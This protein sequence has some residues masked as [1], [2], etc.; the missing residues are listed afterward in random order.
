MSLSIYQLKPK[1]QQLLQPLL[2][3]LARWK[4][5]PNQVTILAVLLSLAYGTSLACFPRDYRLWA[6][7][8]LFMFLRMALNAIDGMLANFTGQKTALGAMLNEICD[9]ISDAALVLPFALVNGV[10]PPLLIIVALLA[11]LVEFAGVAALLA[12]SARRFDGPMGKSDRAFAFGLLGLL[13]AFDVAA[14]W[15]NTLLLVVF[16]LLIWTL[17]NRVR[18][19]L[20]HP[21][22]RPIP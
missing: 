6:C 7:L 19:S 14:I 1:F 13:V 15:M 8:P 20:Q 12:G 17:I 3:G 2:S 5:S 21:V 4:I 9:Q 11:M 16:L 18:K 22:A 10:Q